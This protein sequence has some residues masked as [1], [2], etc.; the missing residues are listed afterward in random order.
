[1]L[2]LG[3]TNYTTG[4]IKDYI[5]KVGYSQI[6]VIEKMKKATIDNVRT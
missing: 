5:Q 6:T 1:M 4:E 3:D 2:M